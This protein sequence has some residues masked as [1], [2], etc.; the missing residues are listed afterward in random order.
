VPTEPLALV[1]VLHGDP[2]LP[3]WIFEL[4]SIVHVVVNDPGPG[5]YDALPPV[6]ELHVNAVP[7]GFAANVNAALSRVSAEVVVCAN[8]DLE[9]AADVPARLASSLLADPALGIVGPVLTGADGEP[10]FSVGGPPTAL[11]EFTR[12]A[13]LRSG[14]PQQ[15]VR[16][17]LRRTG[18]WQSRNVEGRVLAEGEYLPWTCVAIRRQAWLDVGPLDERFEMYAEDLDWGRRAAAAGWRARLVDVG[19]VVHA[20][21]A[22]RDRRTDRL[23]EQSHQRYHEKWDRPDLA[24]WQRRGLAL[25]RLW[26]GSTD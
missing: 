14:R 6:R 18:R 21:R 9:M 15:L 3:A 19:A 1:C 16:A 2:V 13:G 22:T 12:A 25:R 5:R 4:A 10:V 11:K 26:S 23:Y 8:F 24:R 20:E 7:L 17:V